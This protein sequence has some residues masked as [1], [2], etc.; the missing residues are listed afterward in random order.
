MKKNNRY[1]EEQLLL[2]DKILKNYRIQGIDILGLLRF[3]KDIDTRFFKYLREGDIIVS[4]GI[5]K[6]FV[7]VNRE[8]ICKLVYTLPLRSV[9]LNINKPILGLIAQWRLSIGV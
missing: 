8:E 6:H 2:L 3:Y 7:S 9:P 5:E 1:S 4:K